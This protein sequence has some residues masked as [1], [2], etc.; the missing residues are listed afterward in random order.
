MAR[1]LNKEAAKSVK[2]GGMG[3][4]DALKMVTLNPA[5]ALHVDDRVG[6]I[7][8]GKDAD[9]VLWS[10]HPLSIYAKSLKTI[11]D[12]IAYYD[13]ERDSAMRKYI[14][15]ERNR[16]IQK[17]LAEKKSGSPVSPA[18]PSFETIL[19]CGDHVHHDGLIT[20]Y[21]TDEN[22]DDSK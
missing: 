3:E 6:S 19:E 9:L 22:G 14:L 21:L 1:R 16:L 18:T 7:K 4:E 13:V 17:M 20:I 12:G 5:K 11:V 15:S 8:V 2:Y 10:D